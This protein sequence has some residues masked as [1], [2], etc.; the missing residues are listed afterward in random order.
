MS[1]IKVALVD[2]QTLFLKGLRLILEGYEEI[3]IVIE[4]T[5]GEA[6]F[7][8]MSTVV[9]DVILLDLKMPGM[10]GIAVAEKL[11]PQYP[12]VKIILLT[13]HDDERFIQHVLSVGANGYLLKNE[14][15][16][17]LRDAINKVL[18]QDYYLNDYVAKA[19]F[20]NIKKQQPGA[21]T[22]Q[23]AT[24]LSLTPREQEILELICKEMTT[25]E[26][27]E[28]LFISKRTVEGHRQNLLDKTGVRNTA[29]LVIF[30]LKNQLVS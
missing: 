29:G 28:K 19:L 6:L 11:R 22:S 4:A 25:G 24:P 27:A 9:P 18:N 14:E 13:M 20:N 15:P 2:D 23:A 21:S 1:M 7:T 17:V 3:D 8:A 5:S 16:E 26:I 10:D 12:N 30:A